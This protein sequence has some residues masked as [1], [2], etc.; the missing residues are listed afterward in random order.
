MYDVSI[1][2]EVMD[3]TRLFRALQGISNRSLALLT[4][5]YI[6]NDFFLPDGYIESHINQVP[7]I[8]IMIVYGKKDAVT[9]SLVV[10]RLHALLLD[11]QLTLVNAGHGSLDMFNAI[12]ESV[13]K[14]SKL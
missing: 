13:A 11:S 8:P 4:S 9:D 7:D 2:S 12:R 10:L 14:F 5:L 3:E 1:S 6:A